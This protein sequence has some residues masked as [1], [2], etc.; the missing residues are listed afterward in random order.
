[1]S[2]KNIHYYLLKT[3]RL[4]AWLLLLLMLLYIL[5]GFALCGELGMNRWMDSQT[6]LSIHKIFEWPLVALFLIHASI[7]IYFSFRRWGWIKSKNKKC[8]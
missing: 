2:K 1:M 4:S 8:L 5:T 3:A 7:T 6:A